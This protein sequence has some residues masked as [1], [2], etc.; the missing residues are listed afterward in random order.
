MEPSQNFGA[1]VWLGFHP[2]LLS[3]LKVSQT[4]LDFFHCVF[5]DVS[6]KKYGSCDYKHP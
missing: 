4:V 6:R 2:L 3:F 1:K 5:V